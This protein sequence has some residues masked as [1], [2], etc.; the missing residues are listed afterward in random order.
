MERDC[1]KWEYLYLFRVIPVT[2]CVLAGLIRNRGYF[3]KTRIILITCLLLIAGVPAEAQWVQTNGPH[4]KT[5]TFSEEV[6]CLA[7]IGN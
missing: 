4:N 7:T 5:N 6:F 3:M 2:F 1:Y